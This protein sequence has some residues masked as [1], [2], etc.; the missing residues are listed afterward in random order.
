M[1]NDIIQQVQRICLAQEA[2]LR[3]AGSCVG[4][5]GAEAVG[6]TIAWAASEFE[7]W[8]QSDASWGSCKA[9]ISASL[10]AL[11]GDMQ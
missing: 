5:P 9:F 4:K 6:D 7:P 3:I 10:R 8:P 2:C 11:H 1:R